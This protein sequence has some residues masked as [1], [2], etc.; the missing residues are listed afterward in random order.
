METG[1]I[2]PSRLL[3]KTGQTIEKRAGDDGTYEVGWWKGLSLAANKERFILKTIDTREVVI[4]NATGLMWAANGNHEGCNN[5]GSGNWNNLIDYANGLTFCGF[6]DWRMPNVNELFSIMNK[7]IVSPPIPE[8]PFSN[9]TVGNHWTSTTPANDNSKA[10]ISQFIA[11]QIIA[12]AKG[13]TSGHLIC[14]RGG[15]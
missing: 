12:F 14:V 8:P 1:V 7:S 5:G 13:A 6:S 2:I 10:F 11:G 15:V 3:P 4:D 9:I